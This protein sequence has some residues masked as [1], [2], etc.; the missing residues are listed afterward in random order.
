MIERPLQ[1]AVDDEVGIAADRRREMRVLIKRQ[2]EVSERIGGVS[3]LLERPQHQIG[4]DAFFRL[5]GDFFG[6]ALVVLR[7]NG[8]VERARHRDGHLPVAASARAALLSLRYPL[9]S[10]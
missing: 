5:A 8:N 3:R 9:E 1:Y 4:D 6:Q 10:S 7:A 2:R